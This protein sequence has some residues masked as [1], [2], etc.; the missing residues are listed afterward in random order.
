R[1]ADGDLVP[2][3]RRPLAGVRDNRVMP[4]GLDVAAR[5]VLGG[6]ALARVWVKDDGPLGQGLPPE[7]DLPLHGE[8]RFRSLLAAAG[9]AG[10]EDR[11]PAPRR[12]P[13]RPLRDSSCHT[14]PPRMTSSRRSFRN[15]TP[16]PSPRRGGGSISGRASV[17]R[18]GDG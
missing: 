3:R 11:R 2:A 14:F 6:V 18:A 9:K 17:V 10:R 7:L 8:Q 12:R 13:A 16:A 1:D 15:P 4:V 5:L